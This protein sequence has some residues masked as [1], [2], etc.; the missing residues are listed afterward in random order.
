MAASAGTL[1]NGD[2]SGSGRMSFGATSTTNTIA[3]DLTGSGM[4]LDFVVDLTEDLGTSN[5]L[6]VN[7]SAS[8]DFIINMTLASNNF[9][10]QVNNVKLIDVDADNSGDT[11]NY[12]FRFGTID[13]AAATPPPFTNDDRTFTPFLSENIYTLELGTGAD[14]GD[15]ILVDR[16]NPGISSLAG[17]IALTQSLIGTVIN[18]PTSPFVSGLAVPTEDKCGPGVWSRTNAGRADAD[19]STTGDG[20]TDPSSVSATYF[21]AQFGADIGCYQ[22]HFNEWDLSFGV[23]AGFNQGDGSQPVLI[24]DGTGNTLQISE[25]STDLTQ[26]Y[27]GVYM[28][29][30]KGSFTADL[31]IRTETTE[32]TVSNTDL[33][34]SGSSFDVDGTTL[35]GAVSYSFAPENLNGWRIVPTAGI[36]ITDNSTDL[37]SFDVS[38][39]TPATLQVDDHVSQVGFLGATAAKVIV[40]EDGLSATNYFVT[41]TYYRDFSDDLTSTFTSSTNVTTAL[42]SE[43]LGDYAE[44][45][46]GWNYIKILEQGPG[47]NPARQF[48][49]SVRADARVS[50]DLESFGVTGQVRWQF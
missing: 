48:N 25:T 9:G 6:L 27:G 42:S 47:K 10:S 30:A 11:S 36:S 18:R 49:A 3:G 5:Q 7:G 2:V 41:G 12:S 44:I 14:D 24:D 31:Q 26:T 37:I 45:S 15:L 8:G 19:G 1:F 17:N 46:A 28:T 39:G 50:S 29:A 23:F 43:S 40:A 4:Q 21:G 13:F 33:G 38:G 32:F 35:S 16:I 22:G 20:R 34:L